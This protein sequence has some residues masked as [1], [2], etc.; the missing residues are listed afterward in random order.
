LHGLL[1]TLAVL[2]LLL[3]LALSTLLLLEGLDARHCVP[4]D[5]GLQGDCAGRVQS[6]SCD[7]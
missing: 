1:S 4:E 7:K 2:R 5:Q 3:M 6:N